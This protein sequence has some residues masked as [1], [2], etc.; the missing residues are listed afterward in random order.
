MLK[1]RLEKE[2]AVRTSLT[3]SSP[4][5]FETENI[6][7]TFNKETDVKRKSNRDE[8]ICAEDLR[9][10]TFG[11]LVVVSNFQSST[12]GEKLLTGKNMKKLTYRI[13]VERNLPNWA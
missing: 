4:P 1:D 2:S 10:R 3:T 12:V 11:K 5:V 9:R 7:P 6:C 8:S 13:I